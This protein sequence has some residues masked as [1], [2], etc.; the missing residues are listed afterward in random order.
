M[1]LICENWKPS[2]ALPTRA[3]RELERS[4]WARW[5][6]VANNITLSDNNKR[7][8]KED[9]QRHLRENGDARSNKQ[10]QG[11]RT[12][13]LSCALSTSCLFAILLII[14]LAPCQLVS[15]ASYTALSLKVSTRY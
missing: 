3:T 5:Q 10:R 8:A 9:V 7:G 11:E 12:L 1:L 15:G 6:G 14:S 13:I 4:D 2:L